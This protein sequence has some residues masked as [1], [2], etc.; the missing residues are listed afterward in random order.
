VFILIADWKDTPASDEIPEAEPIE[1]REIRMVTTGW[2][3]SVE[4]DVCA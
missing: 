2:E 1:A 3:A 4:A